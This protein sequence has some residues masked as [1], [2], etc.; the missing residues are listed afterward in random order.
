[1]I[2]AQ[3][4]AQLG[5]DEIGVGPEA[6]SLQV[7]QA[8]YRNPAQPIARRMRAALAALP[9]EH[10]KL[11]ATYA[12]T[13]ERDFAEQMRAIARRSGRSMVIDASTKHVDG[14]SFIKDAEGN[15]VEDPRDTRPPQP[16]PQLPLA[17]ARCRPSPGACEGPCPGSRD[18]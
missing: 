1:M 12:V 15:W 8:I 17:K 6:T 3:P 16:V 14:Q 2:L 13:G 18:E 5:A 7:M 11:S 10:P 4:A 9:F